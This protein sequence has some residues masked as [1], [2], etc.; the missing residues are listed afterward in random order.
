MEEKSQLEKDIEFL[1]ASLFVETDWTVDSPEMEALMNI[2]KAAR[3]I[4]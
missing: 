4:E 1:V 3:R 2:V